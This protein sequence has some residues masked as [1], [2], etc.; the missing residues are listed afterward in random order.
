MYGSEALL[1]AFKKKFETIEVCGEKMAL[2][3]ASLPAGPFADVQKRLQSQLE[4]YG[5]G[6]APLAEC[7][8]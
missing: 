7:G 3:S 2:N 6:L 8:P 4:Q 5:V 1:S